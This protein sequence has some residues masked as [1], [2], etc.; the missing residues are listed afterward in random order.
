M[1]INSSTSSFY[2]YSP[3]SS[4]RTSTA[5]TIKKE[6]FLIE[7]S[8]TDTLKKNSTSSIV[9]ES[10]AT[11]SPSTMG[12]PSAMEM[13]LELARIPEWLSPFYIDVSTLPGAKN[14][15]AGYEDKFSRLSAAERSEYFTSLQIHVSNMYQQNGFTDTQDPYERYEASRSDAV[16]KK[17]HKTF[18][19]SVSGDIQ[20]L[21]LVNKLGIHLS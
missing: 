14:Y 10:R 16:D 1:N 18:I 8:T 12:R 15:H 9:S 19:E 17:L 2:R 7:P 6:D 3:A 4:D 13:E 11:T 20:L 21:A 5:Q